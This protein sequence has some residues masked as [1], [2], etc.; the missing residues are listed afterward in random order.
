[1]LIKAKKSL[2]AILI[3]AN[4]YEIKQIIANKEYYMDEKFFYTLNALREQ[5][6]GRLE[7]ETKEMLSVIGM[8]FTTLSRKIKMG[9]THQIPHYRLSGSGKGQKSCGRY[10]W[11]IYDL[12]VFLTQDNHKAAS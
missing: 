7:I 1:M 5:F 4:I 10:K 3:Y 8:H 6:G 9:E 11:P 12:A 2:T